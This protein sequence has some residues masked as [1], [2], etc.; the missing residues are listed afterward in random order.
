MKILVVVVVVV[1]DDDIDLFE[2]IDFGNSSPGRLDCSNCCLKLLV[3]VVGFIKPR[4]TN[5]K[6]IVRGNL[7]LPIVTIIIQRKPTK[8]VYFVNDRGLFLLVLW[9]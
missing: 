5:M 8:E 7:V 6:A 3:V 9:F 1:V 2:N 4:L